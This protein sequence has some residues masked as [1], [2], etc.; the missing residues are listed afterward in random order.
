MYL[1][2]PSMVRLLPVW[3]SKDLHF[4]VS[5]IRTPVAGTTIWVLAFVAVIALHR[6]VISVSLAVRSL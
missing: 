1:Y 2:L 6:S 3:I 4:W 5:W